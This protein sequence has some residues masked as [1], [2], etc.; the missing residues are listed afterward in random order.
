MRLTDFR[1]TIALLLVAWAACLGGCRTKYDSA[2]VIPQ[3][4]DL[5][6]VPGAKL[7]HAKTRKACE[8]V[9]AVS[10]GAD[11]FGNELAAKWSYTVKN[12]TDS[13]YHLS[14]FC[15]PQGTFFVLEGRQVADSLIFAGYWRR[16]VNAEVGT[17]TFVVRR[18][19]GANALLA[20]D[21][22][23]ALKPGDV[24]FKGQ[25][26]ATNE[27]QA[28]PLTLSFNR[29][30][31]PTLFQI[32][33]HRGGGAPRICCPP[34]KIRWRSSGWPRDWVLRGSS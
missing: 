15:E 19:G 33:A 1:S 17:A 34:P 31:N 9:Y 20:P 22:C 8:G 27:D 25:W 21:C 5:L 30:L 24:V 28:K 11:A 3:Q 14:L 10:D 4:A 18:N 2:V 12:G 16:L 26:R 29:K 13:T 6:N 7:L 23:Q 32:I